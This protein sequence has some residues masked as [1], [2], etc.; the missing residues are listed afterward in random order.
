MNL[1]NEVKILVDTMDHLGLRVWIRNSVFNSNHVRVQEDTLQPFLP[2][3]LKEFWIHMMKNGIWVDPTIVDCTPWFL[4]MDLKI[5]S[6][7][8]DEKQCVTMRNGNLDGIEDPVRPTLYL[9]FTN[10][11]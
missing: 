4:E 6:E 7:D 11:F 3:P 5:I 1:P 10:L 8:N 9:G 2:M